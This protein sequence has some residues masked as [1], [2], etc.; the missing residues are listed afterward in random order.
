[1]K[2]LVFA[3]VLSVGWAD[4]LYFLAGK[5]LAENSICPAGHVGNVECGDAKTC[6][7]SQQGYGC[8]PFPNAVCCTDKVHCCPI[9]HMCDVSM[10]WCRQSQFLV[11]PLVQILTQPNLLIVKAD[12]LEREM[13]VVCPDGIISCPSGSSCCRMPSREYACC[14]EANAVCCS[15]GRHCCPHG[16]TCDLQRDLCLSDFGAIPMSSYNLT[17]AIS[18][19]DVA[20]DSVICP[21]GSDCPDGFTCCQMDSGRWG[22]CPFQQAVCCSDQLH[23]CP[24]GTTCNIK[25]G[26]CL[27]G[28]FVFPFF[29]KVAAVPRV[30]AVGSV[31]CPDGKSECA[32]G[33]TCCQ[34]SSGGYGCCPLPKAVC[35]SDHLHCCPTGTTCDVS[36]GKCNRG[37]VSLTWFEKVAAVSRTPDVGSVV[38]PD[39][40]SQCPDGSTCC[41]LT[42]GQ[43]GCCP[44][45]KAVCCSDHLHCCPNGTTCDVSQG[46]CNRGGVSLTW[47][48][49][50]AAVPRAPAV[51]SV[52]CPDGQ[53]QC[54]DGST[55]CKLTSGQYGCCPLPK[56]VCCSDHLH[57]CPNGT[58]CD[59]SQGKCNRG[60]V[61]LTWFE[62]VAAVPRA[63]AVGSVVCPD[64]QSQ[65]PDGSTCC[66]LS[67][68][69]Y[70]CCPLPKAVCCSD[71]LHCCPN[72]TTCDVSQGKCNR[73]SVSLTWFEKVAAVPRAPAVGSVV[74]P[75]GQ[76]QCPDGSTCCKLSSGQYGC[77]PLP[78]AVCCSDHLHCCPN[79]TT[80]DVSQGKCNRGGV[81]LTWFEKVAAVPAVGSVVCPDGQSQCP[82]GSTCCK[83]SS[84]QY[85]CC[86][87][88]KAVC[89]SDHLHCCPNGTT[90]DVSQGKCNR[91][92]V[93]LTW[94][95]KVAA[96]P[97]APAVG[98]VVCPD[99][100]SQCPDGSTCCK[101]SSGQ[102]G[103]CPLPKAVCCSDH[104]HCCPTGTTCD[105]SQGK[106]NRGSV[107][108]TWFEKVAAVPRAPAVGSVVCPDGQ[109]QCPDGSTCCKLS[110]GQY[111]CCPLPKAVCCSDHLHCCP[112]GTT[113]DVSQGKC[114]R[115]GVSLTWFE[116]VAAV[117]RAPAVGSV[118]CPDGQSQCPYGSTCCKLSSGQYGCC[119]L[120]KAV[121]CS[122][123]LHCCPTGTTCDV[124]QG[125]CNRGSV[126]LTWFEKVA[127]VPRTPAVGSVMCPDGQS[128]C[129]D[130]STCCKL[131]SGQY[132]CC[133]L[134]KAVCCSDHLHCCPT[135]T[136]CDVSQGK[137]NRG[138]V[139]LTWFE[140]VAAVPRAPAVGS[141]VCPD[142]QS[143]CPDG[144]TCCKL[145]SGQY[146]CCPLPKAV[147]CSDHLHCCPNGTTCDV[148]Q[149]KCNR[150]GVSLTWFEKVAAVP[151]APDVGSVVCPDGQ[152][153]CP[154]GNTCCK[155]SSGQYGCCPLPKAVC[156]S[157]H[158]HCCPNG[159]TCDVSQGKCNR[160]S[161]SL[162]WFEKVAAVPRA[163][164]VGSVVCP[165]GQSQCPDGSTCCK[166]SSGQYG[167]CPLPKAEC[168]SDG[169]HCC[170]NG[171]TCD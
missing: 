40:Q 150:G 4:P 152:S 134:P 19:T 103:C 51:G 12:K 18:Q 112:N 1:M 69:Q 129:P 163:P 83:L 68:G 122:D 2:L 55:C 156:C 58:T 81:S 169:I 78:K 27:R 11:R 143:Q 113:C 157:D 140:K 110:S 29:E 106:C 138:S 93:S 98:S 88:P 102:Y 87:L 47:F 76:S 100:Q 116:K 16:M 170:P 130:G 82:D 90:C 104:L 115:G 72:G 99:G 84:G 60:S 64:G 142:G 167:C 49:K 126:S 65:C 151:R 10:G 159:T 105:V 33:N 23:C 85:G 67:S 136:T 77:C 56:A 7:G 124:S 131:S 160:G 144:S 166:L 71:H 114:N 42:S 31:V 128:Q 8:C 48:E 135:G 63:P 119:P 30:P 53:S 121:C 111:G 133:P 46:K 39:G 123:H 70:G 120:P 127:A 25:K 57:C 158:L 17:A 54:P 14:P 75:D 86:P 89:C 137:C 97:R 139:S 92:S 44:L 21:D 34:L 117:P 148:S 28:G 35:C 59:V 91:G 6:C 45:P 171:Y 38:C 164:A 95:E 118:V 37:G 147:C 149:G 80:C 52:V 168:C 108:L 15:D 61:S 146:G 132:G 145:S 73:G 50:V 94:F 96:V 79:G 43:Y 62:K 109:S 66:K 74:C 165:D 20:V 13:G 153:Q 141:V 155:L 161:V 26:R 162:T 154:D 24:K 3:C 5:N 41:K 32:D 36:Q 125:K 101:L 22:C 107:S 9:G